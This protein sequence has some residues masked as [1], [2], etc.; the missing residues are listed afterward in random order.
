MQRQLTQNNIKCYT[1]TLLFKNEEAE[2]D[3]SNFLFHKPVTNTVVTFRLRLKSIDPKGQA[4][5]YQYP[6]GNFDLKQLISTCLALCDDL[7]EWNWGKE[8][9]NIC[10]IMTELH[11]CMTEINNFPPIKKKGKKF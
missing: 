10:I 11:C 7:E 5:H 6:L 2:I 4:P 8:E 3:S 9:G 1:H